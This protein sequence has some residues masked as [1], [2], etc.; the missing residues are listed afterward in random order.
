[1]TKKPRTEATAG[2]PQATLNL[3]GG[4]YDGGQFRTRT[5]KRIANEDQLTVTVTS[6]LRNRVLVKQDNSH[7]TSRMSNPL[8][9]N[10]FLVP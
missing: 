1:M 9:S 2:V 6:D 10:G 5:A 4:H 8:H 3:S 7:A